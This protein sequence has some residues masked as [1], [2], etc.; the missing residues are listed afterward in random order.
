MEVED[1]VMVNN[2]SESPISSPHASSFPSPAPPAAAPSGPPLI[3]RIKVPPQHSAFNGPTMAMDH[4][5]G[6]QQSWHARI[7]PSYP[8]T[9]SCSSSP[10]WD[11]SPQQPQIYIDSIVT[12]IMEAQPREELSSSAPLLC[13]PTTQP[14]LSLPASPSSFASNLAYHQY[15]TRPTSSEFTP[16]PYAEHPIREL[17]S[18]EILPISHSTPYPRHAYPMYNTPQWQYSDQAPA[19]AVTREAP[20]H[21]RPSFPPSAPSSLPLVPYFTSTHSL[22]RVNAPRIPSQPPPNA[23]IAPSFHA[24]LP[25]P[26]APAPPSPVPSSSQKLRSIPLENTETYRTAVSI[27]PTTICL[28][29]LSSPDLTITKISVLSLLVELDPS[30]LVQDSW[31]REI[32]SIAWYSPPELPLSVLAR[33]FSYGHLSDLYSWCRVN[34]SWSRAIYN[35]ELWEEK[36]KRELSDKFCARVFPRLSPKLVEDPYRVLFRWAFPPLNIDTAPCFHCGLPGGQ[37]MV[38]QFVCLDCSRLPEY[39]VVTKRQL[40]MQNGISQEDIEQLL[41]SRA[42]R[43]NNAILYKHVWTA[44]SSKSRHLIALQLRRARLSD[45]Y[46]YHAYF[47]AFVGR[48]TINVPAEEHKKATELVKDFKRLLIEQAKVILAVHPI[49]LHSWLLACR[50]EEARTASP[51]IP[52]SMMKSQHLS[53]LPTT[54]TSQTPD[55]THHHH[56]HH[57]QSMQQQQQQQQSNGLYE[58]EAW[59]RYYHSNYP[60]YSNPSN[61][62]QP[63][64]TSPFHGSGQ[65]GHSFATYPQN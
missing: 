3:L 34:K 15:S 29:K 2:A 64:Y 47:D 27:Q 48:R 14:S 12:S 61:H 57:Q 35:G 41:P 20:F 62:Q 19:E 36:C 17:P 52:H 23:T 53:T 54:T 33:L 31:F 60:N 26:P 24:P 1:P 39:G 46:K 4:V 63:N 65:P 37:K 10:T 11:Y 22:P 32:H 56:H 9:D 50:N 44:I 45:H 59:N 42:G 58:A 38:D 43:R 7:F 6:G 55:S 8:S 5:Q 13:H 16:T 28:S 18:R 40:S 21:D 51:I 30:H 49:F 25:T